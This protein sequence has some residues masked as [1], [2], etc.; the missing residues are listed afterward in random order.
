MQSV[1]YVLDRV[2]AGDRI[3]FGRDVYGQRWVELWRGR[4]FERRA[5]LECSPDE[6]RDIKKALLAR[7]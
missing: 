3:V 5:K 7:H 4:L 6:I 1:R 2:E